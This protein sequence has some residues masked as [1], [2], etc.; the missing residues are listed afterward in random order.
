MISATFDPEANKDYMSKALSP[1][2]ITKFTINE[3]LFKI[4]SVLTAQV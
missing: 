4:M 3:A 2:Q 1:D